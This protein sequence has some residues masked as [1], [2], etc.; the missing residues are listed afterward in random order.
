MTQKAER[1]T[2]QD[3]IEA[4]NTL[5]SLI[6]QKM[7]NNAGLADWERNKFSK[8]IGDAFLSQGNNVTLYYNKDSIKIPLGP[9]HTFCL[10]LKYMQG[11]THTFTYKTKKYSI[12]ISEIWSI[13]YKSLPTI[14]PSAVKEAIHIS[15][16]VPKREDTSGYTFTSD[17]NIE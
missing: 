8:L 4:Q 9:A 5:E 10:K 1:L 16:E 13:L 6:H 12:Q 7:R 14:F 3:T 15:K 11:K 17:K 2:Y